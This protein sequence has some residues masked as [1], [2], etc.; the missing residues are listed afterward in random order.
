MFVVFECLGLIDLVW[1]RLLYLVT[2]MCLFTIRVYYLFYVV[3]FISYPCLLVSLSY[4][5]VFVIFSV[6]E[7]FHFYLVKF[8]L[9]G[10]NV[11]SACCYSFLFS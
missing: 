3:W 7:F 6:Y 11:L 10:Y 8:Y 4:D 5:I 1:A 9:L 2:F